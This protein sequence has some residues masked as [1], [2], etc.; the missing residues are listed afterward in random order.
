MN[1]FALFFN[2][3][4]AAVQEEE[5]MDPEWTFSSSESF[6]GVGVGA[7]NS[8]VVLLVLIHLNELMNL[9]KLKW[10]CRNAHLSIYL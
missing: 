8:T 4:G 7:E 6:P 9:C 10:N 5:L 2:L 3:P 1:D